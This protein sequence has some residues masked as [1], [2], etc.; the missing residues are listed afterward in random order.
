[1]ALKQGHAICNY[2]NAAGIVMHLQPKPVGKQLL[3]CYWGRVKVECLT[4]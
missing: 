3:A 4:L 1:M 2:C